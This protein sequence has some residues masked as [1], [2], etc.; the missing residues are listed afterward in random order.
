MKGMIQG[1]TSYSEQNPG[2]NNDWAR[3]GRAK[4][5]ANMQQRIQQKER[6]KL[7]HGTPKTYV[8]NIRTQL[9]NFLLRLVARFC[10]YRFILVGSDLFLQSDFVALHFF[11]LTGSLCQFYSFLPFLVRLLEKYDF[12]NFTGPGFIWS[13]QLLSHDQNANA[14]PILAQIPNLP[15]GHREKMEHMQGAFRVLGSPFR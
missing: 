7:K 12:C 1:R 2:K 3:S 13:T 6:N 11:V 9:L 10:Y 4:K 8:E 5:I 14:F 15:L